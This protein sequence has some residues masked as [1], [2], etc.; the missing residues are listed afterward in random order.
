MKFLRNLLAT[1]T[2]VFVALFL[3]F[4]VF[5]AIGSAIGD[6]NKVTVENNSVLVLKLDS[7][8]RDFYSV[9]DLFAEAFGIDDAK[10]MSLNKM[11]IAIENAKNDDNIKGISIETKRIHAGIA[12][13]QSLRSKLE[14][15]KSSGKFVTAYADAYSQKNYYLSSVADSVFVNPLG[16]IDFKGLSAEILYYKDIQ[17]KYG[18]KMEVIR[19]GKYKSAVEPFLDNKMSAANREQITSLLQSIWQNMLTEIGKSRKKS[20]KE[21][22]VIADDLGARNVKLALQNDMINDALYYNVYQNKIKQ[23][24]GTT[25]SKKLKTVSLADYISTGKGR[26]LSSAKNKIA[27]IYAQGDIRNGDGD[28]NYIGPKTMIKYLKK[29]RKDKRIKAVVLRVNSPG[30]DGL[31][32]DI[33]WHEIELTKKEKPVVVSMGNYAASGGYYIA[34]N[35]DKIIAQP[36]TI[37]GSIGVFGIVPNISGFAK[38]IGINS[39]QV[40]TNKQSKGYS[41]FKPMSKDF[42]AEITEFIEDFYVNFVNRVAQGRHKTFSEIDAIA[43][44]RVW[45]GEQALKNGLVDKLGTLD[46]AV[47]IAA[48]LANITDFKRVNYPNFTKDFKDAFKKMPFVSLK[49]TLQSELGVDNVEIYEQLKSAVK[50]KGI[51]ARVPFVMT[52]K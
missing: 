31:A 20:V 5:I 28:E 33:I 39:E 46:D 15:F 38:N 4:I 43:Q 19:H 23:L 11:L 14:D 34:C 1:I 12:Q 36:T 17:E 52:V 49:R 13:I 41:V 2:G 44:G 9:S 24:I 10:Y 27:V 25:L 48:D 50:L 51:Q 26:I 30:G 42:R 35:A 29:A 21:L 47:S 7:E 45:T 16:S 32:S 40:G 3:I 8:I 18:I 37:T 6:G 22:N